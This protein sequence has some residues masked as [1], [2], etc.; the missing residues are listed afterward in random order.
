MTAASQNGSWNGNAGTD[1]DDDTTQFP[2]FSA[3]TVTPDVAND[4]FGTSDSSGD[5]VD[6]EIVDS[7]S[8]IKS[9][10]PE[11]SD[12]AAKSGV[13]NIDE[14]MGFFSRVVIRM[15]TDFYIDYAFRGID[16]DMLSDREVER[17][18]LSESERDRIARPFAEY[19]Y[20]SKFMRKHGRMIIASADSIDAV[21]QLGMWFSRVNRIAG[22]YRRFAGQQPEH[23][24]MRQRF[25][26]TRAAQVFTMGPPRSEQDDEDYEQEGSPFA[27]VSSRPNPE[28]R[29][30]PTIGGPVINTSLG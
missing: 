2:A 30:R 3:E 10:Y 22:K 7:G 23:Q 17:I 14:W 5:I 16:E 12:R 15:S 28:T 1:L 13:P 29:I 6:G 8:R 21:L 19:S 18:K 11:P 27:N 9:D 4:W 25:Q 24:G 20:K 26:A